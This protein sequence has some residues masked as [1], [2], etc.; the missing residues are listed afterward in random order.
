MA[1]F[2]SNSIFLTNRLQSTVQYPT[3][4]K[5]FIAS[6]AI[7]VSARNNLPLRKKTIPSYNIAAQ[8][9][10]TSILAIPRGQFCTE[11]RAALPQFGASVTCEL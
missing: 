11:G 6:S 7:L 1:P 8:Y 9:L 5:A 2:L 10:N 3:L 4:F